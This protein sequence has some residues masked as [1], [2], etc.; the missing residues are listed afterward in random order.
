MSPAAAGGGL[1]LEQQ[2]GRGQADRPQQSGPPGVTEPVE[3][4]LLSHS[5]FRLHDGDLSRANQTMRTGLVLVDS[6]G[7]TEPEPGS[8]MSD[9]GK[10][11]QTSASSLSPLRV[12]VL[13]SRSLLVL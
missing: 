8:D 10:G 6:T 12:L 2:A 7:P 11:G 4:D 1:L 3:P 13:I 5:G 9:G